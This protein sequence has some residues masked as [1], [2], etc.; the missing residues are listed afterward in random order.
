M[1]LSA[2]EIVI[3]T[4]LNGSQIRIQNDLCRDHI[5]GLLVI[6]GLD[7]LLMEQLGG[8]TGGQALVEKL[9]GNRGDRLH[10][11]A[12]KLVGLDET[13]A[14]GAVHL[15]WQA[16]DD[17]RYLLLLAKI[18][19]GGERLLFRLELDRFPR[20]CDLLIKIGDRKADPSVPIVDGEIA[21][22]GHKQ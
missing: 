3:R 2:A 18:P 8:A 10:Q 15:D 19:K 17:F 16:E 7:P 22:L 9:N 4:L 12:A 14:H 20:E 11:L 5:D 6:L 1:T 21:T 13:L